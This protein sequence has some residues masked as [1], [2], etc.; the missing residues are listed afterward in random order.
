MIKFKADLLAKCKKLC[1]GGIS[2]DESEKKFST[3]LNMQMLELCRTLPSSVQT[4]ALFFLM[5]YVKTDLTERFDFFK[6]YYSPLWTIL[7]WLL[8]QL[9][10]EK[11]NQDV[12][13][14]ALCGHAMA[15]FLHSLDD[16]LNDGETRV[17]HLLL[18]LR[19]QAWIRLKT[20]VARICKGLSMNMERPEKLIDEYYSGVC[21]ESDP[22]SLG[23]Y[24][25]LFKKQM[26]TVLI[27]PL[28][29]AERILNI[30]DLI[31]CVRLCQEEF[32]TAWRFVDDI[33]DIEA[34][35]MRGVHTSVYVELPQ[36]GKD[37]WNSLGGVHTTNDRDDSL[38]ALS[39]IIIEHSILARL[40]I[41]VHDCLESAKINAQRCGFTRLAEEYNELKSQL[42]YFPI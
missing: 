24:V 30:D 34:D 10:R 21:S 17:S 1:F 7:H 42:N 39:K 25:R 27:F 15:M 12:Y 28:L 11:T 41:Q 38:D 13:E 9:F 29:I 16:H 14:E 37:I 31:N 35:A 6:Y 4:K 2:L 40:M 22:E 26:S 36:N 33:S 3:Q 8:K 18:L 32:C 19:S 20:S 23:E 5:E